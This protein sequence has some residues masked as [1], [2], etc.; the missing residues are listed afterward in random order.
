MKCL[1]PPKRQSGKKNMSNKQSIHP[2]ELRVY[3]KEHNISQ[4][5][6]AELCLINPRRIREMIAG[7]RPIPPGMFE[8]LKLKV[9]K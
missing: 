9:E 1:P 7:T 2:A 5:K 4:N 8:F 6:A 3:L